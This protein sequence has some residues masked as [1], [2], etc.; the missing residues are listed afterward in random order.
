MLELLAVTSGFENDTLLWSFVTG[1]F[2]ALLVGLVTKSNASSGLKAVTNLLLSAV[3]GVIT[4]YTTNTAAET[5][6]DYVI[7]IGITW[8]TSI[9]IYKGFWSPTKISDAVQ[10]ATATIGIGSPPEL[11]VDTPPVNS[12]QPV[13]PEK[14]C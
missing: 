4:Q 2:I 14:G 3:A 11:E 10:N 6:R 13:D 8:V 7:A 9:S 12:D 5:L 1:P